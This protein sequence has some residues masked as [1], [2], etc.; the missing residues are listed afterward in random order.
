MWQHFFL[1]HMTSTVTVNTGRLRYLNYV[2]SL[3]SKNVELYLSLLGSLLNLWCPGEVFWGKKHR[4]TQKNQNLW[5]VNIYHNNKCNPCQQFALDNYLYFVSLFLNKRRQKA[6][7][8]VWN[9]T[10]TVLWQQNT[11]ECTTK[12]S[13]FTF[14]SSSS[15][16]FGGGGGGSE[17]QNI[18]EFPTCWIL[19][20]GNRKIRLL[21]LAYVLLGSERCQGIL[22]M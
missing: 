8:S 7:D 2:L 4:S 6:V 17:I 11:S 18:F 14:L 13:M 21:I 1:V 9:M 12:C 15:F 5:G 10:G 19:L 22:R 20:Q 3:L 16:F